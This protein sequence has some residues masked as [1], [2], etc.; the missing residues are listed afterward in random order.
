M[1]LL[2]LIVERTQAISYLLAKL[3]NVG[4]F[5][6]APQNTSQPSFFAVCL[7]R[8]RQRADSP[9]YRAI[10]RKVLDGLP[11]T[12]ILQS[13]F[14]SLFS[15]VRSVRSLDPGLAVRNLVKSEATLLRAVLGDLSPGNRELWDVVLAVSQT[16]DS[17]EGK[18]R[19]LA[20]WVAA[21]STEGD[22]DSSRKPR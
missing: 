8:I 12:A 18:A 2:D 9:S 20:C 17:G 4:A 5:S 22:T 19:V 11:S 7:P 1:S 21:S 3:V 6:P 16:R 14:V 10:W 13:I 15:S